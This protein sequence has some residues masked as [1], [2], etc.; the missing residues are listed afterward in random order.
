MT[1]LQSTID[2]LVAKFLC[3]RWE[4]GDPEEVNSIDDLKKAL[5]VPKH[6]FEAASPPGSYALQVC[7]LG[8]MLFRPKPLRKCAEAHARA[9]LYAPPPREEIALECLPTL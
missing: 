2:T 1:R 7:H 4:S 3:D 8:R 5:W 9:H 6:F